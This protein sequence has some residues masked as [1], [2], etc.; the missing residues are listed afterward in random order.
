MRPYKDVAPTLR[1]LMSAVDALKSGLY[2]HTAFT[3]YYI[4][5]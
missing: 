2:S 5:M 1:N 4:G 3:W